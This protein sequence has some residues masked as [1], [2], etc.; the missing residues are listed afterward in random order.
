MFRQFDHFSMLGS[1]GLRFIAGSDPLA[2]EAL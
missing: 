2:E 1:S